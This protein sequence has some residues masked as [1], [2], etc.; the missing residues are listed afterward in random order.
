MNRIIPSIENPFHSNAHGGAAQVI[1]LA[2]EQKLAREVE[3]LIELHDFI[4]FHPDAPVKEIAKFMPP[5]DARV[6][7]KAI[8]ALAI[9]DQSMTAE[10]KEASHSLVKSVTVEAKV[11]KWGGKLAS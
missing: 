5:I 1:D 7:N 3:A 9:R 11:K 4:K 10:E 8:Q 2:E 6:V